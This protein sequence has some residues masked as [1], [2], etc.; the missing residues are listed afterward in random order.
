M[1]KINIL[2]PVPKRVCDHS[3]DTCTY[4]KYEAPHPSPI[5]S[6][7]LSKDWD[8]KK[9]KK[10]KQRSLID[11][12]ILK[13]DQKQV[14]DPDMLKELL[15]QNLNIHKNRKGVEKLTEIRH[16]YTTT[17]SSSHTTD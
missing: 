14:T 6:D 12:N 10:R 9:A 3:V 13:L 7:C 15:I 5:P 1:N 17:R 2:Q 4:C 11:L 16:I 8:S